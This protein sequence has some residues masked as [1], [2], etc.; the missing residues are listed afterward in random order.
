[1]QSAM[2]DINKLV[3]QYT[4]QV[5]CGDFFVSLFIKI[6]MSICVTENSVW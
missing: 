6:F 2:D 1:M 5:Y 4:N 3:L